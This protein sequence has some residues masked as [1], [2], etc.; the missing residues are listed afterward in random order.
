[1][2]AVF[3]L[4]RSF[5]YRGGYENTVLALAKYAVARGHRATIFTTAAGDLESLWQ[6]GFR[7][8]PP[9][10]S[11]VDGVHLRRFPLSYSTPQR[12]VSRVLGLL[13]DW[14]VKAQ[15][16]RPAFHAP[17]LAEAL[18]AIDADV[19]HVGPL[20]HAGLM[21]AGLHAGESRGVPVVAMPCPHFGDPEVERE[22]LAPHQVELLKHCT[23]LL[24]MTATERE[25]LKTLGV[26]AERMAVAPAGVDIANVT[27]GDPSFLREKYGVAGPV[28]LHL[29][30]KAFDK[31]S[32]TV[33]EA[34]KM[35]WARGA[36]A[37]LVMAGPSMSAFD[38]YMAEVAK[39]CGRLLNL[40][41]YGDEERRGL[42]AI[43][44]VV[45]QPSR[46]ES[47]GL[48]LIEAWANRT[49]VIA[50]DIP[51]SR[52]LVGS[53]GGALV[54]F[55]DATKLAEEIERLLGDPE[56]RLRMGEAGYNKA[57]QYDLSLTC[58]RAWEEM[59]QPASSN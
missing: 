1:M 53:G 11:A 32:Q 50:A 43:A 56:L 26:A 22:Y 33:V 13:P 37:W 45:A 51:V 40:P 14:R 39:D 17:G 31:G 3:V 34:M 27:G 23:R 57:A 10:E 42:L 47:L 44:D 20:P 15:N 28:V 25:H 36:E 7:T 59:E 38:S 5:P 4:P 2:H 55:G 30:M 29:G 54:R 58:R 52:E 24:C 18:R 21:Y 9:G 16:W 35:L 46:V 19:F 48:V 41:A 8:F 12:Y 6:P 49:P